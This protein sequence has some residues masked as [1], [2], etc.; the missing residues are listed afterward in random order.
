VKFSLET[1]DL[2]G[3]PREISHYGPISQKASYRFFSKFHFF[4]VGEVLN[5]LQ[6]KQKVE[7]SYF[8]KNLGQKSTVHTPTKSQY[9]FEEKILVVL[10]L[11]SNPALI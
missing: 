4:H 5:R 6:A 2:F 10:G 9:F 8:K 7:I 3:K 1:V 11:G